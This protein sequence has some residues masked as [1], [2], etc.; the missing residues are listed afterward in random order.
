MCPT[1]LHSKKGLDNFVNY[2]FHI[3]KT[4]SSVADTHHFTDLVKRLIYFF[5]HTDCKKLFFI[6]VLGVNDSA[7][8]NDHGGNKC[9][10]RKYI[11][12]NIGH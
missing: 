9:F 11:C 10:L 8:E 4:I 12:Q 7:L 1:L 3:S 2:N 6:R 5:L